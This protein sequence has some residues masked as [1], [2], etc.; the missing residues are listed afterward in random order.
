MTGRATTAEMSGR[1]SRIG[2]LA[3]VVVLVVTAGCLS[4][5]S[6]TP[7]ATTVPPGQDVS[8]P[9][10][11][12]TTNTYPH[13]VSVTVTRDGEQIYRTNLTFDGSAEYRQLTELNESGEYRVHVESNITAKTGGAE[14]ADQ[15]IYV[16]EGGRSTV[17]VNPGNIS[18]VQ[19]PRR[20][21][22]VGI[23]LDLQAN[24]NISG[25][26]Y[27]EVRRDG[28]T[29]YQDRITVEKRSIE[30]QQAGEYDRIRAFNESGTY[31]VIVKNPGSLWYA[32]ET[33]V[34]RPRDDEQELRIRIYIEV[35]GSVDI[36]IGGAARKANPWDP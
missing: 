13:H 23:P 31:Q 9:L 26:L 24:T 2:L 3:I 8:H 32:N 14:G 33:A 19:Q 5:G 6:G 10:E 20:P 18:V 7:T 22:D 15:T 34:L 4:G 29:V 35:D 11:L 1:P 36:F 27:V 12:A 28:K 25:P 16:G 30:E 21:V 17:V